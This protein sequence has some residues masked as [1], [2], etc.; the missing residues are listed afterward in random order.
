M[1]DRAD[2]LWRRRGA[3]DGACSPVALSPIDERM[4]LV[5]GGLV[6]GA[7]RHHKTGPGERETGAEP[8]NQ[9]IEIKSFFRKRRKIHSKP[10]AN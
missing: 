3:F 2:R 5:F 9:A 7:R 8:R 6:C 4:P 1:G 10:L